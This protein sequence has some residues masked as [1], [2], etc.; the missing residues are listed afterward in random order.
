MICTRE[1][2]NVFLKAKNTSKN[3]RVYNGQFVTARLASF[4][5]LGLMSGSLMI[6]KLHNG[7]NYPK[8]QE[9]NIYTKFIEYKSSRITH[10]YSKVRLRFIFEYRNQT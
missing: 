2:S 3:L 8:G 7:I 6:S 9:N 4:G 10:Q 5:H 1:Y